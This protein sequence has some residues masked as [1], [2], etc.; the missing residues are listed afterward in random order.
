MPSYIEQHIIE[1]DQMGFTAS[2][3]VGPTGPQG[4]QGIQ[5]IQGITGP[6]GA[7]GSTG[8]AGTNGTNGTNGAAGATGPT[9]PAGSTGPTGPQGVPGVLTPPVTA[10][11]QIAFFT[12]TLGATISGEN[13]L[14]WDPVNNKL[15]INT[16]PYGGFHFLSQATDTIPTS[17]TVNDFVIG[18]PTGIG[19][20][21][22]GA[23][24]M[25]YDTS[26]EA[27][28]IGCLSPSLAWRTAFIGAHHIVFQNSFGGSAIS[29]DGCNNG[30]AI[31]LR[32]DGGIL[33]ANGGDATGTTDTS[34]S[35]TA[36]GIIGIGTGTLGNSSGTAIASGVIAD[37]VLSNQVR[38]PS[39]TTP[40]APSTGNLTNYAKTIAGYTQPMFRAAG[41]A[42][43]AVLQAGFQSRSIATVRPN[44]NNSITSN[45]ISLTPMGTLQ[46]ATISTTN[47]HQQTQRAEYLVTVAATTAIAGIYSVR[48]ALYRGGATGCGG[49]YLSGRWGPTT[50]V[51]NTTQ[52]AFCGL[53]NTAAAPTDVEPSS[54]TNII[55]MGWDAAD[56]NIQLMYNDGS[57]T[58][59][60]INLGASFPVPTSDRTSFYEIELYCEPNGSGIYYRVLD[61]VSGV[62]TSGFV[63]TDIPS[64]T[65][66]LGFG[67]W[68]SAG[69]TSAV[70]GFTL[71]NYYQESFT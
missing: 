11:G 40:S 29:L 63:S 58:A 71:F 30:N 65:S 59:S 51:S 23:L 66:V 50:G 12:D 26:Q 25:R 14:I 47:R 3:V 8:P 69:G 64:A 45:G 60:K 68:T 41:S 34:L 62:E 2:G 9:G 52:R 18:G 28:F 57:G 55:G 13:N 35:R 22:S 37:I 19:P 36:A 31:R 5:G 53:R 24:F 42:P 44:G 17:F 56:T 6:T 43:E 54:L 61:V 1:H 32:N 21:N 16:A 46:D 49:F 20:G 4:P 38:Q 67:G 39:I 70:T 27:G 48:I 33:W 7:T 10:V 15:G